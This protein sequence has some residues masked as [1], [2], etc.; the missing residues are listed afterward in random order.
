MKRN[1]LI[2]TLILLGIATVAVVTW[3]L[4]PKS[5]IALALSTCDPGRQACTVALPGGGEMDFSVEPRP[6]PTLR[7][8]TLQITVSGTEPDKVEV[9]FAGATMNMGYN[10]PQLQRKLPGRF[11][12][13]TS[14]PVCVTGNMEWRAT[15]LLQ[16]AGKVISAPFQFDAGRDS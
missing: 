11:E 13:R 3:K 2:D 16:R 8:I 6:I 4:Q 15:V 10:R 1:R 5:D 7:P 9:D 12:G 14:L